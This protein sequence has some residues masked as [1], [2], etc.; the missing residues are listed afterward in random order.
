MSPDQLFCDSTWTSGVHWQLKL[1]PDH[2]HRQHKPEET[3]SPEARV[4][5]LTD[6]GKGGFPPKGTRGHLC[7]SQ[8]QPGSVAA[9][10]GWEGSR[11]A[12]PMAQSDFGRAGRYRNFTHL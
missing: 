8:L 4:C 1:A 10:K 12:F 5:S 11:G 3:P 6:S 2:K 7:L 9:G